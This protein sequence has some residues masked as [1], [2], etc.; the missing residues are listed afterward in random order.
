MLTISLHGIKITALIGMY[1]EE[2]VNPNTFETDVDV[3]VD[4]NEAEW[5]FIDYAIIHDLVAAA[6][7]QPTEMLETLVQHIHSAVKNQFPQASKVRVAVR[8][9]NPPLSHEVKYS[10]VV[11]EN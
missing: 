9:L 5:P 7:N 6:F 3:W 8:K 10:Q 2:K 1:P 4:G 11:Y